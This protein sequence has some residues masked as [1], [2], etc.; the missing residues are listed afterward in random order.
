[1]KTLTTLIIAFACGVIACISWE[2]FTECGIEPQVGDKMPLR[3]DIQQS[4]VAKGYD[5][6]LKG[7]DGEIGKDTNAAWGK[8]ECDQFA[9]EAL[10]RQDSSYE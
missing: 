5:I 6:G 4:L 1:M 2:F 8:Y 7:V 9:V 10:R 3:E